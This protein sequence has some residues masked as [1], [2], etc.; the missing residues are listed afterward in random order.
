MRVYLMLDP[1]HGSRAQG[2]FP[3]KLPLC[4]LGIDCRARKA[5]ALLDLLEAKDRQCF[6][7][8]M[9]HVPLLVSVPGD[10]GN[11]Y[12]VSDSEVWNNYRIINPRFRSVS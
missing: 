10:S 9:R 12:A 3:R 4:H 1:A 5:R 11:M 7:N 6:V 8:L 2:Y